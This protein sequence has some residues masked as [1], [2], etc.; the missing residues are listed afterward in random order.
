[1]K[2]GRIVLFIF[3]VILLLA[4]MCAFF[5]QEG[6]HCFNVTL[7]FPSLE[8]V[9]TG[10]DKTSFDTFQETDDAGILYEMWEDSASMSAFN[11][12]VMP[13]ADS[14]GLQSVTDTMKCFE[15]QLKLNDSYLY[16][17][18]NQLNYFDKFFASAEKAKT[19]GRT[20]RVLHYGDS[21]IELDRISC[22]IREYFQ[23]LFGGMGPGLLPLSQTVPT[24]SVTQS[25]AGDFTKYVA[26]GEG[27]HDASHNYGIMGKRFHIADSV[28]FTALG[29][30]ANPHKHVRNF[31]DVKLLFNDC[32]GNFTATLSNDD[33]GYSEIIISD[34]TGLDMFEWNIGYPINSMTLTLKGE[35]DIY[36]IMLDGSY[37]V[38]VDNIPMRGSSGM[39]YTLID[40]K[41]LRDSYLMANVGLIIMQF[42]GNSVPLFCDT[43]SVRAFVSNML[44]QIQ[45]VQSINPQCQILFVGPADMSKNVGG[46]MV[47]YPLLPFAIDCLR[48]ALVSNGVAYWDMYRMMGGRN[49]MVKWVEAGLA[50]E[51]YIHFT[52]AGA[53]KVGKAIIN[54]FSIL[55]EL[56]SSRK[57]CD[58]NRDTLSS[59]SHFQT[60]SILTN[61]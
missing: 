38:S 8:K 13:T 19:K 31:S 51:D 26:Y 18:E 61:K 4:A 25:V 42:G 54:S 21:Q 2:V 49:S 30:D 22:V 43:V 36:G 37:G 14:A 7:R 32:N 53:E 52:N 28:I 59:R 24:Y 56:Y 60:D 34:T 15:H 29:N 40:R 5:P 20:V 27:K 55:Y 23:G 47:T 48:T 10:H 39:V 33:E 45:Y 35:A 9:L 41:Q 3:T 12:S 58:F 16:L 46:E 57:H 1:M 50:G 44:R 11:D 17:P 6:V